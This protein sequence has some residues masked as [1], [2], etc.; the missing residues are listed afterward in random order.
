MSIATLANPR[1]E[2][3]AQSRRLDPRRR[4][5]DEGGQWRIAQGVPS[6]ALAKSAADLGPTLRC[7][8]AWSASRTWIRTAAT[9]PLGPPACSGLVKI[10]NFSSDGREAVHALMDPGEVFGEM[11][12]LDGKDRSRPPPPWRPPRCSRCCGETSFLSWSAIP[13]SRCV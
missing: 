4:F 13:E 11:A 9:G 5:D 3:K 7:A 6:F 8:V 1:S 12:L 10:S 2:R